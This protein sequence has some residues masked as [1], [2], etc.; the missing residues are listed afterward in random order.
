MRSG[1]GV[2]EPPTGPDL[3]VVEILG[4]PQLGESRQ[5]VGLAHH[6]FGDGFW[7]LPSA[8]IHPGQSKP[9]ASACRSANVRRL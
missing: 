7:V 1:A 2:D 6:H 5:E 8:L 3:P 9:G 4:A